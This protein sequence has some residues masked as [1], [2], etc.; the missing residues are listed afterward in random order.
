MSDSR[1]APRIVARSGN[2]LG[3][4]STDAPAID[5]PERGAIAVRLAAA[6]AHVGLLAVERGEPFSRV[7]R[8]I[9]ETIAGHLAV[10]LRT[11]DLI[12][13]LAE[14]KPRPRPLRCDRRRPRGWR[15]G[16]RPSRTDRSRPPHII[17]VVEPADGRSAWESGPE[18]EERL[19]R[20][21]PGALCDLGTERLRVLLPVGRGATSAR[22]AL[23]AID[24]AL[25]AL[26]ETYRLAAGRSAVQP[27][28]TADPAA[29][30]EAAG[31]ARIA[32]ALDPSGGIRAWDEL[33]VYRYL[34]GAADGPAPDARHAAAVAALWEYD[35]R[36]AAELVPTLEH[37][38]SDRR[39]VPTA[40]AL[41]STRIRCA[42]G[43]SG[44]S[45]SPG[46]CSPRRI[47]S[48]WSWRSRCTAS[49]APGPGARARARR[50]GRQVP[51]PRSRR[52]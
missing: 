22:E 43:S 25:G 6:D 5:A 30:A 26:A 32:R 16:A 4:L 8:D 27:R 15:G 3:V 35:A 21:L 24:A 36:R 10:A 7:E 52:G 34:A 17:V 20:V 40:R 50:P 18:V 51:R 39:I 44:W 37:Y 42:S 29:L 31:A 45:R 46:S 2:A 19:R 38:L 9:A 48:R 11:L 13:R 12:A 14:E 41:L 33:G 1:D 23:P 47:R 49:R 28:L